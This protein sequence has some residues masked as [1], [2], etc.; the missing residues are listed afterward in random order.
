MEIFESAQ[1]LQTVLLRS[2]ATALSCLHVRRAT[3][4]IALFSDAGWAPHAP[5]QP[6]IVRACKSRAAA[7]SAYVIVA[8]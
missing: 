6:G 5:E 8:E 2:C 3:Q 1:S 7:L 4:T